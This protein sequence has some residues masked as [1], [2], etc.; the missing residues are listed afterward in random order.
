MRW[1][2]R[3][4]GDRRRVLA[5]RPEATPSGSRFGR[6]GVQTGGPMDNTDYEVAWRKKMAP[7]MVARRCSRAPRTDQ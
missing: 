2:A 1:N 7:E 4:P 5:A 3:E 6:G